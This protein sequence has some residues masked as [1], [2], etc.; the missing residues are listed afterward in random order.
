MTVMRVC[1]GY[2]GTTPLKQT[3]ATIDAAEASGL[4]GVWSAEHVG[5]NDAIVPS[6]AYALRTSRVEIGLVGLNADSR[7]P[8]VLAMELATLSSLAP[9]R[10]RIQVGTGSPAHA[11]PIGVTVPRTV[12]GVEILVSS[13]RGLLRGEEITAESEAFTLRGLRLELEDMPPIPID[14]MAIRPK[15]TELAARV[16]DGISLSAGASREYLRRRVAE[17]TAMLEQHGRS[18]AEFRISALALGAFAGDMAAARQM[19]APLAGMFSLGGAPELRDGLEMPDEDRLREV[20]CQ[21][22]PAAAGKLL[23]DATIEGFG[24]VATPGTIGD[25]VAAYRD[26]GIDELVVMPADDPAEHPDLVRHLAGTR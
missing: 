18:R 23:S 25:A 20:L 6:T 24:L 16:A 10:I 21:E 2:S 11:V 19:M 7:H 8:G 12:S 13:L 3:L 1:I 26:T 9:G 14:I 17:V 22:G 5:L 15:M 4:D